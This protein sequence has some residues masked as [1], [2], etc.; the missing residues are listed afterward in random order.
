MDNRYS[1]EYELTEPVFFV[2]F[3]GAG[4]TS[5]AR[6]LARTCGCTSIDMDRYIERRE[7]CTVAD[8]FARG[9]ED[10]FRSIETEI[11]REL[12][13]RDPLFISCG[14]GV[15][16]TDECREILAT[17]GTVVYLRISADAAADRIINFETRP[18]FGDIEHARRLNAE[19]APVYEEVADVVV[20]TA[21]RS[22]KDIAREVRRALVKKGV[23]CVRQSSL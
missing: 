20:D 15:I 9:G 4:K 13:G 1:P 18:L 16:V 7:N 11:L 19:R 21:G 2:G 3:M 10:L 12:S 14:G 22:V 8:I 17:Q 5:T 6:R 23:L